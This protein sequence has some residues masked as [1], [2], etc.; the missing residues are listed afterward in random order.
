MTPRVM[1]AIVEALVE[2]P[3]RPQRL[4]RLDRPPF[5]V[6]ER[7]ER[8]PAR[9]EVRIPPDVP[10]EE[11]D[12]PCPGPELIDYDLMLLMTDAEPL[13]REHLS[14]QHLAR[15]KSRRRCNSR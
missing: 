3:T 6:L 4:D 9:L 14:A 5:H 15:Y 13:P 1:L 2:R 8:F 12:I 11:V 10:L 7:I